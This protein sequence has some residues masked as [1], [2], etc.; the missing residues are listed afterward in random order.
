MII[1]DEEYIKFIKAGKKNSLDI[2]GG[3]SE[4]YDTELKQYL[5]LETIHER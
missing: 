1:S 3:L 2:L 5:D 4:D